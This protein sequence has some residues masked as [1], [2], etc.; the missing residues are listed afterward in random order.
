M[1]VIDITKWEDPITLG[2]G[3]G[4]I[5]SFEEWW[6]YELI[7]Q[8]FS[9]YS[10]SYYSASAEE[11]HYKD[12]RVRAWGSFDIEQTGLDWFEITDDSVYW[13]YKLSSEDRGDMF[14]GSINLR[15]GDMALPSSIEGALLQGNDLITGTDYKDRII[16]HGGNDQVYGRSGNDE[17]NGGDGSDIVD[18]GIG[19]DNLR[20]GE[21]N[22]ELRGGPGLDF[23]WGDQGS[24][25]LTAGLDTVKDDLYVTV[26]SSFDTRGN[27]NNSYRDFLTEVTSIDRIYMHGIDDAALVF[28]DNIIDPKGSGLSGVGIYANGVLEAIVHDSSGLNASQI[29]DITT[30]IFS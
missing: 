23:L 19:N 7:D 25:V 26:E 20:G 3:H 6:T 17:L 27:P 1:S 10:S 24:N 28:V 12:T 30:G 18:G 29:N 8:T 4:F 14:L 9:T 16:S 11:D 15:K 13:T 21:G 5:A 22:D 2:L